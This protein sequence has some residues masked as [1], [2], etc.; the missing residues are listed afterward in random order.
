MRRGLAAGVALVLLIA[1]LL[2]FPTASAA[3]ARLLP[4]PELPIALDG[5]F[6]TDLNAPTLAPGGS[7]AITLNL[8]DPLAGP[9]S[10][11]TLT[12]E[13]YAFN[14]FPGNATGTIPTPG[15]SFPSAPSGSD[16]VTLLLGPIPPGGAVPLSV[17][18]RADASSPAG[19]YAIRTTLGFDEN[20]TP[21]YLASRGN[22][23]ASVWE[24]AT[25]GPNGTSTLN[26][27]TLWVS[28]VLPETGVL[29]QSNPFP[30]VVYGLF[31][32]AFVLAGAGGYYWF[33]RTGRS[34]SGATGVAEPSQAPSAFGKRRRSDGD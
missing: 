21:F 5:K 10:N 18:V 14:A 33:R 3:P 17:D 8:N 6:L 2:A 13:P 20:G 25:T 24:R 1:V 9:M 31:A 32:G 11:V 23:P 15:L 7:G 16:L 12:L 29:V 30:W 28:G 27:T 26:L 34:S 19:L 4:W 22:F